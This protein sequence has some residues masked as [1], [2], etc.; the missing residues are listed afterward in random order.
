VIR[1]NGGSRG[2]IAST[3]TRAERAEET[4]GGAVA[5]GT[6][7]GFRTAGASAVGGGPTGAGAETGEAAK[8]GSRWAGW[9][10][11]HHSTGGAERT[12]AE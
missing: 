4:E 5:P 9:D 3:R 8:A 11:G 6:G 10:A 12:D 7:S 2:R 1:S